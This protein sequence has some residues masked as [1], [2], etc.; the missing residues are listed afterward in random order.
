MNKSL[1]AL[2]GG[3][4]LLTGC[5]EKAPFIDFGRAASVDSA[6]V[7]PVPTAQLHNVLVEEFTGQSCSNCPAGHDLL[8]SI[9][10]AHSDRVN[11]IGLYQNDNTALTN[12]PSG[13]QYDFRSNDANTIGVTVFGKVAGIPTAGI[14]RAPGSASSPLQIARPDWGTMIPGRLSIADSINLLVVSNYD[15]A[16]QTATIKATVTY[17]YPMS[18]KQSLSIV[19]V[20]DSM[21]DKQEFPSFQYPPDGVNPNYVFTNVFREMITA[22][23]WGDPILDTLATKPQGQV[24]WR[25]YTYKPKAE[26]NP[27]IVPKHCRVIAFVSSAETNDKHVYQSAQ[28][29]L[30][31]H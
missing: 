1:I 14:D 16:T 23:P 27:H 7:G 6:Y 24:Y 5:K 17:L 29:T 18:S 10:N 21:T 31:P 25:K 28:T 12:P 26:V 15:T 2:C 9:S 20:E 3:L 4:L 8:E 30:I 19:I 13:Y 11:I 22:V